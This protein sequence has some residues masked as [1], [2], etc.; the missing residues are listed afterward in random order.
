MVMERKPIQRHHSFVGVQEFEVLVMKTDYN[1]RQNRKSYLLQ[2]GPYL[3][4]IVWI[5]NK[6]LLLLSWFSFH[7]KNNSK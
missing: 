6:L 1:P 3:I 2:N 4:Y 5:L 7:N